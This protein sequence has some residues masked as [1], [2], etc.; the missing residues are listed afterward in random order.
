MSETHAAALN[1]NRS[2]RVKSVDLPTSVE[3]F[4]TA[5]QAER[6]RMLA[7][8][9]ANLEPDIQALVQSQLHAQL[10]VHR[11]ALEADYQRQIAI[12]RERIER[13]VAAELAADMQA[14]ID[15]GIAAGVAEKIQYILEQWRLS[16]H[17][18]FGPSSESHQGELF[19]EAETLVDQ[20]PQTPDEHDDD[21]DDTDS[22]KASGDKKK[23]KRGHRRA[24]PPEL[25]RI[26]HVIDVPEEQRV[27]D[28]GTPMVR[29]G[30]DV[31]EQLDIVPMQIRV[32]RTVRPRYACVKGDQAPV[33]MPAPAQVLP[34]S[35]FS[36]GFLAMLAVVKYVDGLPLARFE[37]VLAR[38]GVDVPRQSLARGIIKLAQALQPLHNLARDALLDSPVIYMDETTVQVLKE[39]GRSPT[40]TSYMWVQRGGPPGKPVVLFDYHSS[41]SGQIPVRL[42]EGW[43]G[44]LMTDGYEGYAPVARGAGVEHLACAA[45]ARRKFVQAKRSSPNGKS[46]RADHA[47]DLFGKLYRIEAQ[48][49]DASD[50]ERFEARQTRSLPVLQKLRTW[51]DD[52]LPVVTP[53]SKLG[54]A[55]GYLH[56]VWSRLVR[57]TERGD[58]PIDNN[59]AESAIRPFV[60]G[61][62][63]WLFSDTPAG[64][65]ASAVLYSLLETAKANGREPYAW[66][67]FVV[68][69]L[70]LATTVD[71]IEALLPWNTH[72]QDLAMNLA[73]LE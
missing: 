6:E 45:H 34:R 67:R 14:K 19:N 39:P 64:A 33:Q 9:R 55:L 1:S 69:R 56:K 54:E 63:A 10:E 23:P 12:E 4:E 60:V 44:Y 61:R 68:E 21:S 50:A 7:L 42:L 36:A 71:E 37:K 41:R 40:S 57:Y 32:I 70:P 18:R 35:N 5:L 31:S 66:L 43:Q 72:D 46:A 65:H 26:E 3:A 17:R 48:L 28:C 47:L 15:E 11:Q 29:I 2:S 59:P 51:L 22:G 52:T 58:L 62:K 73:A 24:L 13:R 25:P 38:H 53:K 49:K 20:A 30:E 16:R 27:C 8:L